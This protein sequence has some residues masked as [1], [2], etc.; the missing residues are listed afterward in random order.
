MVMNRHV[1]DCFFFFWAST[2]IQEESC[3]AA[4]LTID[5][6]GTASRRWI[7]EEEA[8]PR[9]I[10]MVHILAPPQGTRSKEHGTGNRRK[11]Q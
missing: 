3:V 2:A 10:T 7:L 5:E 11:G 1:A 9:Q 8:S 4:T 6:R